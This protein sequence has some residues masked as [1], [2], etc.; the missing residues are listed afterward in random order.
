MSNIDQNLSGEADS[1][2]TEKDI[3]DPKVHNRVY[4]SLP[5]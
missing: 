1:R 2:W 3:P 4:K 5:F